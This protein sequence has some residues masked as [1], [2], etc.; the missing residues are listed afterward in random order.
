M[1]AYRYVLHSIYLSRTN[2]TNL[3]R[4]YTTFQADWLEVFL[5]TITLLL[6]IYT[7]RVQERD[8]RMRIWN[9]FCSI[10][11]SLFRIQR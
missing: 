4:I 3:A 6:C 2:Q 10:Q 9:R 7:H 1:L 8:G 5:R 11:R